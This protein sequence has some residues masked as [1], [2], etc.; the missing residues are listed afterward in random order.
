MRAMILCAGFGSRLGSLTKNIPKPLLPIEGKPI[1]AYII[2]NIV[3]H[4]YDNI[5]INLHYKAGMIENYFGDGRN[6][7]ARIRYSFE[8]KLLGT[9]GGVKKM[10]AFF[11]EEENFLVHYGDVVTN[12]DYLNMFKFHQSKKSLATLLLHRRKKSN[13]IVD[14]DK[15][16]KIIQFIERPTNYSG[17]MGTGIWVNSGVYLCNRDILGLIPEDAACDFPRDIFQK[18]VSQK[19][20]YGYPLEGTRIAIDSQERLK[21]AQTAVKNGLL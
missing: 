17:D 12:Q 9:A 19:P 5:V 21:E 15:D 13:S 16:N 3:L 1:L 8:E 11:K 10:E 4:G 7:G 2:N 6:F 18:Y 14:M 20:F